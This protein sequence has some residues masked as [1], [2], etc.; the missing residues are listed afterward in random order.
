MHLKY[1]GTS[2]PWYYRFLMLQPAQPATN[3]TSINMFIGGF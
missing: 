2:L 3:E 1:L